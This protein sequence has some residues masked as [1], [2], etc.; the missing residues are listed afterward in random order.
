MPRQLAS[1]LAERFAEIREREEAVSLELVAYKELLD[2]SPCPMCLSTQDGLIVY[3]NRSYQEMLGVTLEQ[4][5]VN[6]WHDLIADR[7]RAR[8]VKIWEDTVR[9]GK[10]EIVSYVVFKGA[11]GEIT[12]YWRARLLEGNGYAIAVY[13][14]G[15]KFLETVSGTKIVEQCNCGV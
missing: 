1:A 9:E 6:G 13:H 2:L 5:V 12:A 4:V 10:S 8:V 15:C 11:Q 14:P 7:D 3:V